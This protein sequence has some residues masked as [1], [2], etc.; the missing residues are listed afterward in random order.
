[1]S[2]PHDVAERA[3]FAAPRGSGGKKLGRR[4]RSAVSGPVA[5]AM[6]VMVAAM[7]GFAVLDGF[8]KAMASEVPAG[9]IVLSRY[10]AFLVP[11]LLWLRRDG[12][13]PLRSRHVVLQLFRSVVMVAEATVF[14][15]ALRYASLADANAVF[16]VGPIIGVGL[17]M[18][19]LGER[20]RAST[21]IAVGISF[22]GVLVMLR[23]SAHSQ[24]LGLC[25]AIVSAFL[26]ALYGILTR[27]VSDHDTPQTS[28]IY[29]AL[30]GLVVAIAFGWVQAPLWQDP[31]MRE[32]LLLL[33]AA[34]A[35]GAGQYLLIQAYA[36]TS[37]ALL[38]PFN[39]FLLIWAI[40]ISI[41]FFAAPPDGWTLAGAT[42]VVGAGLAHFIPV[43][44]SQATASP[45]G[46]A[47][48]SPGAAV[49]GEPA[50]SRANLGSG[51]G[52]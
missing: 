40:P 12:L 49:P 51:S 3:S 20:I 48:A 38:Q 34:V 29:M 19:L 28:F 31:S 21:W 37:A 22:I 5:R 4:A 43:R 46:A 52:A 44:G 13:Q 2:L 27:K 33:G 17:A 9:I 1:M 41:I 39:Y 36:M 14:V 32:G 45:G 16:A 8:R 26:Y 15:Y 42:L 7:F 6:L 47:G 35:A 10:V 30:G 11:V 50:G 24:L 25:L 23:P 18:L